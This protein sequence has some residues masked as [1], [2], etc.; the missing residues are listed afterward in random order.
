MNRMSLPVAAMLVAALSGC[1]ASAPDVMTL[2]QATASELGLAS[3]D[4]LTLAGIATGTPNALGGAIVSYRATTARGRRF[5]CSTLMVPGIAF[6]PPQYSEIR[7]RP[8]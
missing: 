2:Q 4:E 8:A 5:S 7:C 1:A 6:S 3:T